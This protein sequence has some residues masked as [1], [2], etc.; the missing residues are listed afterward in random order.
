MKED[1]CQPKECQEKWK[2][3][4]GGR[5]SEERKWGR[6][7][8]TDEEKEERFWGEGESE[9]AF[10]CPQCGRSKRNR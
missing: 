8:K 6:E 1:W 5:K 2:P 10:L 9:Q 7:E 4:R 3:S